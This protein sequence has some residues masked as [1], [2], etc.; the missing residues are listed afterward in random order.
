MNKGRTSD[1]K[2]DRNKDREREKYRHKNSNVK[3]DRQ[4]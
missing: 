3:K 2:K 1:G 4:K